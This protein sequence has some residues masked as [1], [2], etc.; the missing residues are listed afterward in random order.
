MGEVLEQ[1][2]NGI[3]QRFTAILHELKSS[4]NFHL[5]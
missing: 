3:Q 2:R 1:K 5:H 4:E